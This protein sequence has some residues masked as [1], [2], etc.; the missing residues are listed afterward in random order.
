VFSA[1]PSLF[2]G[3]SGDKVVTKFFCKNNR[4]T[5]VTTYTTCFKPYA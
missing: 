1:Q 2:G 5:T 4:V 3:D